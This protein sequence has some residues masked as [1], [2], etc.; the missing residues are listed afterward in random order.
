MLTARRP[1][2]FRLLA[3]CLAVVGIA[4]GVTLAHSQK[5]I[6]AGSCTGWFPF[7]SQA[8]TD[9]A[10]GLSAAPIPS[11][12][13]LSPTAAALQ[14]SAD[15]V[16]PETSA[17]P[18]DSGFGPENLGC[19]G[20]YTGTAH[21]D[22]TCRASADSATGYPIVL[23]NGTWNGSSGFG[24]SKAYYYHNLWTKP[25]LDTIT[26]GIISGQPNSKNYTVIHYTDGEIDQFVVV[27]ADTT[28][29]S[30]Q[31]IS[32]QDNREVGVLTGYCENAAGATEPECPGWVDDTV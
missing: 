28:D 7:P 24:W 13:T 15:N 12:S 26:F 5:A 2:P 21:P 8:A 32:T 30:W 29:T 16:A 11:S 20:W 23:R 19:S 6:A 10:Q 25:I 9:C 4:A 27:V 22:M 14:V 3:L 1:L 18:A 17:T 31:G